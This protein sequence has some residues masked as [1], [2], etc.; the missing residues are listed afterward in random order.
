MDALRYDAAYQGQPGAYSEAAARNMCGA[1]ATLLPCDT[2]AATF[3]A[4]AETRAR[5]AVVP[6]ENTLAGPVPGAITLLLANGLVVHGERTEHIDHVLAAP[7]GATIETLREVL[8]HPV[9][10]AQ[11]EQFF[12]Q[13]PAIR[14][15]PVF[16]TAGA[17]QIVMQARDVT[18]AAI[19]GRAAAALYGATMLAEHLQDH[20]SNFTRFVRIAPP[21]GPALS[22]GP[23]RVLLGLRLAH[24]PGSLAAALQT[25]AT[26]DVNLTRLD[27][28]PVPGCPFEYEFVLEGLVARSE[29]CADALE[30]LRQHGDVRLLGAFDADH[31]IDSGRRMP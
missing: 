31:Q 14:A 3:A 21:P 15:V 23:C 4:V 26:F 18:R 20:P 24:R 17:L 28:S 5:A 16:D 6:L 25:L 12:K 22:P 10:L 29:A 19:A 9:A 2:L 11:C 30:S 27:S 1:K 13:H 8:S 7:A